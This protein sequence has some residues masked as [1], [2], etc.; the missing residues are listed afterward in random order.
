MEFAASL[1]AVVSL[2]DT[3]ITRCHRYLSTV[4]DCPG[5]LRS[6]LVETST[7]RSVLRNLEFVY[8]NASNAEGRQF[9]ASLNG[10]NGPIRGCRTCLQGLQDLLPEHERESVGGKRRN[11][12]RLTVERLAWPLLESRARKLLGELGRFRS[13]INL[14]LVTDIS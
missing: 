8:R 14:A 12:P 10:E 5:D 7:V 3:L 1:I 2:A 9:Y 13:T 11:L 4:R 6:I